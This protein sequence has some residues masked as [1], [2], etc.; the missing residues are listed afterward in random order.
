MTRDS[1]NAFLKCSAD[2][3]IKSALRREYMLCRKTFDK[4]KTAP[5]KDSSMRNNVSISQNCGHKTQKN[6]GQKLINLAQGN[7]HK[8]LTVYTQIMEIYLIMIRR[9]YLENGNMSLA[10][11]SIARMATTMITFY[12]K[13]SV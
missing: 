9:K 4:K 1:E 10:H 11:Y 8:L 7:R 3:N 13:Y 5:V 6:S 12:P 2:A